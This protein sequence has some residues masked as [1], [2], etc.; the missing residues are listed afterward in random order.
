MELTRECHGFAVTFCFNRE[1]SRFLIQNTLLHHAI[2]RRGHRTSPF[3]CKSWT[4]YSE[5][6]SGFAKF[7]LQRLCHSMWIT[8]VEH[9]Q[10][11]LKRIY[12]GNDFWGWCQHEIY[13]IG[14]KGML[15]KMLPG[16]TNAAHPSLH[17]WYHKEDEKKKQSKQK[18]I[19]R[20]QLHGHI[21]SENAHCLANKAPSNVL[22]YTGN[23]HPRASKVAR[24]FFPSWA[25]WCS[26]CCLID[27]QCIKWRQPATT[28]VAMEEGRATVVPHNKSAS[29][30]P[31]SWQPW[32]PSLPRCKSHWVH[33]TEEPGNGLNPVWNSGGPGQYCPAGS[34]SHSLHWWSLPSYY[35]R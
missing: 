17:A 20:I 29:T 30:T 13:P 1:N 15:L 5:Y 9:V 8:G 25:V 7:S 6:R 2:T 12:H 18:E 28:T 4:V 32:Q 21:Q 14:I 26:S 33:D 3:N 16:V 10:H 11:V 31:S 34:G 35:G 23:L 19:G 22:L 27:G 24:Q